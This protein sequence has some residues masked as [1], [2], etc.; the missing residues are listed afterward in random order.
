[1]H[2]AVL[3]V[4]DSST[5]EDVVQDAFVAMYTGWL[6]LHDTDN[7]LAYLRQ[8]VVNR[9]RS[10]LRHRV[11]E[12]KHAP[13]PSPDAPS[14][15]QAALTALDA[16]AVVEALRGLPPRQREALVLRYYADLSEADVAAAM[17]ISKGAVKRH[18]ARGKSALR[19][20]LEQS[21]R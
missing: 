13:R 5:A 2:L 6:R 20:T 1:M 15:E 19:T 7:A 3:L 12:D 4:R 9:S 11:V 18:T 10:V 8:S 17:G 14:A 16:S 21:S